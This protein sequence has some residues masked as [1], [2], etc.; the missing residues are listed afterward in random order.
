MSFESLSERLTT[1]QESTRQARELIGRLETIKFEPGS[2]TLDSDDDNVLQELSAEISQVLKDQDED[3]E[4]LQ[5][6]VLSELPV[7][8]PNSELQRQ[9]DVLYEAVERDIQELES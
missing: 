9:R 1:L 2:I 8:R 3:Y 6:A 4:L 7:G 5:E